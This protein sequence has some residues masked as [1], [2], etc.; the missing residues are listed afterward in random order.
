MTNI[1]NFKKR[2][3]KELKVIAETFSNDISEDLSPTKNA[4]H[5]L[6]S[7]SSCMNNKKLKIALFVTAKI[8]Q[9]DTKS[10]KSRII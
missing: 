6:E 2:R 9:T 1:N 5:S 4:E 8:E 3:S 10:D 7:C